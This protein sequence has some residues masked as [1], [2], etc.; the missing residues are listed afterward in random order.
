MLTHNQRILTQAD[1]AAAEE[2][3][4]AKADGKG[5]WH[6]PVCK[7]DV[8]N[9]PG[10]IAQHESGKKHKAALKASALKA[11]ATCV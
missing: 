2:A 7:C 10:T 5:A 4:P 11:S 3:N 6:C 1:T 9:S 8:S